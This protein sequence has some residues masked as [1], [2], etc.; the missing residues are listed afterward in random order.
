MSFKSIVVK[1][2]AAVKKVAA[3][4]VTGVKDVFTVGEKVLHV[5]STVKQ[6]DPTFAAELKQL[7]NDA[8]PIATAL[9]PVLAA[10]G[11]NVVIDIAAIAPIAGAVVKLA[12][13]FI[14]FLPTLESA[15]AALST[16]IKS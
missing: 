12:Q 14:T 2:G 15:I 11:E 7:I 1:V 5:V 8:Q 3:D 16:D 4:V 13:D 6:L 9:A 10:G